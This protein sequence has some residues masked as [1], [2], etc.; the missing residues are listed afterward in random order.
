M[1]QIVDKKDCC[2]CS[3]CV[4]KCPK[5]C[6]LLKEDSE[7]FLYPEVDKSICIDCGL[8]EKVCPIIQHNEETIPLKIL[9]SYNLNE[10]ERIESSSGGIFTLLAK[11]ILELGGVV[12]GGTYDNNWN[13]VHQYIESIDE[14]SKLR[15]TKYVQ[16]NIGKCFIQVESFLKEGRQVLF[17]GTPCQIA[18]LRHF[19]KKTYDNLYLIDVLCHGV[20]S[21]GIWKEYL[22]EEAQSL[23]ERS[24]PTTINGKTS[25]SSSIDYKELI[26][27]VKFREKGIG[28]KKYRFVLNLTKVSTEGK[29][30]SVLVSDVTKN[31]YLQGML[32]HLFI[33]PICHSCPFREQRSQ[34]NITLGDFWNIEYTDS[35]FAD[36]KGTSMI[37][38]NDDKGIKLWDS[39]DKQ[40]FTVEKT[41]KQATD[42]CSMILQPCKMNSKRELF[43]QEYHNSGSVKKSLKKFL[44][45][46][47]VNTL[48]KKLQNLVSHYRVLVDAPGQTCNRFWAY[49]DSVGWAI[50]NN[51]K[52]YIWFWDSSIKYY[53]GLRNSQY[54]SFPFYSPFLFK[55]IG[56]KKIQWLTGKLLSCRPLRE[57]FYK[58]NIATK[59]GLYRSWPLRK[60]HLYFPKV[61]QE[62][63]KI[64]KPND[65]ICHSVETTFDKYKKR[66]FFI[67]GVHIRRGDYKNWENGKYFFSFEEYRNFMSKLTGI[68]HEK[69]LAFFIS[70]NEKYDKSIFSDFT[71]V[72][73][74]NM[75]AA[76]DL[77]G[78]SL[79]DRIIGPLSTFS[80]WASWYGD[81]PLTFIERNITDL[82][83]KSFSVITDFYHFK[84][85][86]E[87][88]NLTDK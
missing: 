14:L 43:Y 55:L 68:Y 39:I 84:N 72:D 22:K 74:N 7:G 36:D 19:L 83:D 47:L 52:V 78:L 73:M 80:R 20:P 6:I 23:Y 21:P 28:W 24:T 87:I 44:K 30:N 33:R 48:K 61:K 51:K 9:A 32:N 10:S 37:L 58:S 45:K 77:Y 38:I 49:L 40:T 82:N 41:Y 12:F 56:E 3:A 66:G 11:R 16:S 75:T 62:I 25:I 26:R 27:D 13:I 31:L 60:S 50:T 15:G 53:D 17:S 57:Y 67:I 79:C 81:V 70:T 4:Q 35:R 88:P 46:R 1:I 85:G 34:S 5:Q 54:V 63:K 42:T 8:C 59:I 86:D 64:F 18:G 2:G 65:D 76:H 29:E 71:L 69:K